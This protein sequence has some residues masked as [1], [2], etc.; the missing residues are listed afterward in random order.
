MSEDLQKAIARLE[1][2]AVAAELV[3][4]AVHYYGEDKDGLARDI[5][6]VLAALK[7]KQEGEFVEAWR[8]LAKEIYET[9]KKAGFYDHKFSDADVGLK[10]ALMHSELSEAL[11][12][13]RADLNDD[14]LPHRKM[15]EVE[16]ADTVIR[17]MN[18]ATHMSLDVPGALVEK[19]AF[20]LTRP[21]KH[22]GKKF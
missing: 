21:H 18:F 17:I 11:E 13:F 12:G 16:L 2:D 1:G 14:K 3:T 20:N 9:G 10:I 7:Q 4:T 19:N 5:R 22:G 8:A 6:L 15:L